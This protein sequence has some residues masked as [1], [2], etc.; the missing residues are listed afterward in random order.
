LFKIRLQA[1]EAE[2]PDQE[3]QPK[4]STAEADNAA[5]QADRSAGA[6]RRRR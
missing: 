1:E 5:Q 3:R 6:E 4:L 2:Q